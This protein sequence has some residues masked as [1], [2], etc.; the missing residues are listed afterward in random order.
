MEFDVQTGFKQKLL[1]V[2]K[3]SES[4]IKISACLARY[5]RSISV[6]VGPGRAGSPKKGFYVQNEGFFACVKIFE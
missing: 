4:F 5:K 2:S 1:I 3:I 6:R